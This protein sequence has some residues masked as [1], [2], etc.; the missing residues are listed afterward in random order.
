MKRIVRYAPTLRFESRGLNF[1]DDAAVSASFWRVVHAREK[2]AEGKTCID[3]ASQLFHVVES[4]GLPSSELEGEK[5]KVFIFDFDRNKQEISLDGEPERVDLVSFY[6]A[7]DVL[8][9]QG[10][11]KTYLPGTS[12]NYA[13]THEMPSAYYLGTTSQNGLEQ[14]ILGALCMFLLALFR[15]C[16]RSPGF[17]RADYEFQAKLFLAS[18]R[19]S[20]LNESATAKSSN[21]TAVKCVGGTSVKNGSIPSFGSEAAHVKD[22]NND[23][24]SA[25][26]I[27][28]GKADDEAEALLSARKVASS[29]VA[30]GS[31]RTNTNNLDGAHDDEVEIII[32][33]DGSKS[34]PN[35]NN[36]KSSPDKEYTSLSANFSLC[37]FVCSLFV[38]LLTSILVCGRKL[39]VDFLLCFVLRGCCCRILGRDSSRNSTNKTRP[40]ASTCNY[41][42]RVRY[43]LPSFRQLRE[44]LYLVALLVVYLSS[45]LVVLM[46]V[47]KPA[48]EAL[49]AKMH[50]THDIG[51]RLYVQYHA[52][53]VPSENQPDSLADEAPGSSP[54]KAAE[55]VGPD[56]ATTLPPST[57]VSDSIDFTYYSVFEQFAYKSFLALVF[58]ANLDVFLRYIFP[59]VY[60]FKLD[61]VSGVCGRC[62]AIFCCCTRALQNVAPL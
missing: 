18:R 36:Q 6:G 14:T 23:A 31:T 43:C 1:L 37:G 39:V 27:K 58:W 33:E 44:Q 3:A 20:V 59:S 47:L 57:T 9:R 32:D 19:K 55:S 54:A 28:I 16:R 24:E 12:M 56:L 62:V 46:T 8:L 29:G 11:P 17:S 10:D 5:D 4:P 52:L 22:S 40:Q 25:I 45:L 51:V 2:A 38:R 35:E 13:W 21:G 34:V 42:K 53:F 30:E 7:Y 61:L 48:A 26:A 41:C 49:P 60:E 15:L 50:W